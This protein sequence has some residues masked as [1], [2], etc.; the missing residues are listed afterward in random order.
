M[1]TVNVTIK[2]VPIPGVPLPV[3]G[4]VCYLP[5]SFHLGSGDSLDP[6]VIDA[7]LVQRDGTPVNTLPLPS[8]YYALLR[9]TQEVYSKILRDQWESVQG[10]IDPEIPF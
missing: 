3:S 6:E 10:E 9:A 5:P 1:L 7:H 2:D 4:E 8:S